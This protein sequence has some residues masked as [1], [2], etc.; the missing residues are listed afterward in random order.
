MKP[1]CNGS[2]RMTYTNI[3]RPKE[4]YLKHNCGKYLISGNRK[5]EYFSF[6]YFITK[7][8]EKKKYNN[9]DF[10]IDLPYLKSLWEKQN[11]ICPYTG[12][13]MDLPETTLSHSSFKSLKKSSL[14]RIDSSKGYVKGNVEF[15][16]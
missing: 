6:K 7:C 9:V 5:D 8:K 11:G 15:V 12:F 4:W 14:D 2:C 10:D 1:F 3:N 16:C 13:K